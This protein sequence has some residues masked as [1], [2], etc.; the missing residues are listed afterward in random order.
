MKP[1]S[2]DTI[3]ELGPKFLLTAY[4]HGYFPMAESGTGDIQWYSPDP[5]AII[6]LDGLKVSRSLRQVLRRQCYELRFDTAFS[7]VIRLCAEREETWI[8]DRIIDAYERLHTLGF[9]HSIE[10]WDGQELAGGLY[11]VA[12][13]GAFFG[14]SMFH[15]RRDASKIALVGLVERLR[16]HGFILLDIQFITPHLLSMG[17]VELPREDY[18]RR[19]RKTIVKECVF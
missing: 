12:L 10:S 11:G 17:A 19:L 2:S 14:E 4:S 18:I 13:G 8:S 16:S 3:D 7:R 9:A 6:E 1:K 15:I 5:R